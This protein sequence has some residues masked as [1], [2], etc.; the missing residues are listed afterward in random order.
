ME[1]Y[2][3]LK[4]CPPIGT[5]DVGQQTPNPPPGSL[6][7]DGPAPG[8]GPNVAFSSR[9]SARPFLRRWAQA[10]LALC[11]LAWFAPTLGLCA[12]SR[13]A[14]TNFAKLKIS[15][16]GWLKDRQLLNTVRL[17]RSDKAKLEFFDANFLEDTAL[18]ILSRV[19]EEGYLEPRLTLRLRLADGS[20]RSFQLTKSLESSL[21]RPLSAKA[22]FFQVSR[23]TLYYYTKLEFDGLHAITEKQ[24]RQ[25]FLP[26]ALLVGSRHARAYTP[27]RLDQS[28]ASVR[29]EL[30][31][32]GYQQA[33]VT[34]ARAAT[35]PRTGAVE[36]QIHV[37]EGLL[38]HVRSV[39]IETA[40]ATNQPPQSV[41]QRSTNLVYSPSW[42]QRFT[43]SLRTNQFHQGYPDAVVQISTRA[44]ETNDANIQLDLLARIT[45]GPRVKVGTVGFEG[46][47]GTRAVVLESRTHMATGTWLDRSEADR[48]RGRLLRLGIFDSVK[49][50]YDPPDGETRNVIYELKEGKTTDLSLM[51]GWG[52][53]E[54]LRGGIEFEEHNVAG[55]A[56]DVR[57]RLG[58]SFKSSSGDFTYTIPD[59]LWEDV[60]VFLDGSGLRR[61]EISFIRREAGGGIGAHRF[62]REAQ[63]DATLRYDCRVLNAQ[64]A[65]VDPP[66]ELGLKDARAT[67]FILD[68]SREHLDSPLMPRSGTKF[69]TKLEFASAALGG[70]VDYE[71]FI[72]GAAWHVGLGGGRY[73][74]LGAQH[75]VTF[76]GGGSEE[77]PFNRR[78]FPGG[79]NSYR[80]VQ[81]GEA[82]PRDAAGAVIGAETYL[83]GNFEFEQALDDHWSLVGFVDAVGFAADRAHY[84]FDEGLYAVGGGIRWR[85]VVG[86]VRL[87]YGYN[88]NPRVHD[89]V[90]TIQFSIGFPF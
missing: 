50:R 84:P 52:S 35:N 87:E 9:F 56:H 59:L 66:A 12:E 41:V 1:D 40:A 76:S 89:P 83:Q 55:L 2:L 28:V 27:S 43:Y 85:T 37:L 29:N 14:T 19:A 48:D 18:T 49:L 90:G 47:K 63:L 81:E 68:L 58:Q 72:F 79:E 74:H 21:P 3:S 71:R 11:W 6:S 32:R 53:Y 80:G 64:D 30:M 62:F 25:F 20:E 22:A 24:A 10:C 65:P 57:V 31:S 33:S 75:G 69:Y 45:T 38:S 26:A 13:H 70:E 15:G 61:E 67:A 7:S 88:L 82:A 60:D 73:L 8:L 23:G 44:S 34:V 5:W 77:L 46:N 51:A 16:C 17:S 36:V 42:L 39:T 86:P 78:F 54:M 4:R